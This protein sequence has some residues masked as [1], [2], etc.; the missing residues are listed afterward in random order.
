MQIYLARNNQQAGPYSLEQ[1]N[2]MLASQQVLLTDLAWHEGMAEWKTL[3]ELTQ[4]KL[5]YEPVGYSPFSTHIKTETNE[6]TYTIKVEQKAPALAPFHSRALAKI[7]DLILWLPMASI[8]SFF[9]NESQYQEL[10][11]IQKQMQATQIASD[12]AVELQQ[13]LMQLI[14]NEAWMMIFTYLIIM[15]MIQAFFI[16]K[17]GQSIGK[18]I[19]KIKIVDAET[20]APVSTIRAFWLRSVFFIF[21]NIILVPI[22]T[23]IDYAL[24]AFTKNRQ[25]LHDKLAKTKV[26]K[27]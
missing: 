20:S 26:I 3:G 2:Q 25:T 27:Q 22:I 6:P 13:Q 21:L 8:P 14:P 23:V 24:F 19:A 9:F 10:F 1:V 4:G 11:E 12:K 7:F 18:K 17:S 5:V 15:L 16:A